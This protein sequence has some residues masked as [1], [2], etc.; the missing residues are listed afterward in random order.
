MVSIIQVILIKDEEIFI[1][2][3]EISSN[4]NDKI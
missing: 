1:C 4:Y 3:E 2:E